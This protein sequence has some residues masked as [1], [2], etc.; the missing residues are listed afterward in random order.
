MSN[1]KEHFEPIVEYFDEISSKLEYPLTS[2]NLALGEECSG[3][4]KLYCL[5]SWQQFSADN[6]VTKDLDA[7][8]HPINRESIC[9]KYRSNK[10]KC[11]CSVWPRLEKKLNKRFP[12]SLQSKKINI[13]DILKLV[14][15]WTREFRKRMRYKPTK[16]S[17]NLFCIEDI[18]YYEK[19]M[20]KFFTWACLRVLPY[21]VPLIRCLELCNLSTS[22]L[23]WIALLSIAVNL[24]RNLELRGLK[25]DHILILQKHLEAL[26]TASEDFPPNQK[27]DIF[28][29][30]K[31]VDI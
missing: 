17:Q 20:T 5:W 28:T 19:I 6:Y 3:K 22:V 7:L 12:I 23:Q 13:K 31:R 4:S 27:H 24:H 2:P 30:F 10:K 14:N 18:C 9:L 29:Q 1:L 26:M 21:P 25:S 16:P 11:Y 8:C 15:F